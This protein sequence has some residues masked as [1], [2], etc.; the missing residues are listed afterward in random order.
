MSSVSAFTGDDSSAPDEKSASIVFCGVVKE[1]V[2]KE[3][4]GFVEGVDGGGNICD[5]D[6]PTDDIEFFL[7]ESRKVAEPLNHCT[8]TH[9]HPPV[10]RKPCTYAS[11]PQDLCSECY[12]RRPLEMVSPY[13]LGHG[14]LAIANP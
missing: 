10:S 9:S 14:L 11:D 7:G 12:L 1:K 13:Q 4:G 8:L 3:K 2:R 5:P 6:G